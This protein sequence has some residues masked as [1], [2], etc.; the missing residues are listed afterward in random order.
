MSGVLSGLKLDLTRWMLLYV[1]VLVSFLSYF[2]NPHGS[3]LLLS[4]FLAGIVVYTSR[5]SEFSELFSNKKPEILKMVVLM[6]IIF[7]NFTWDNI[8]GGR[9]ASL[10]ANGNPNATAFFF[11]SYIV[12]TSFLITNR[13]IRNTLVTLML[14]FVLIMTTSRMMLLMLLSYYF[15]MYFLNHKKFINWL[16]VLIFIATIVAPFIISLFIQD[17]DITSYTDDASR[18]LVLFDSSSFARIISHEHAFAQFLSSSQSALWGI[19]D[20][21]KGFSGGLYTPHNWFMGMLI[22]YGGLYTIMYSSLL[23]YLVFR[24]EHKFKPALYSLILGAGVASQWEIGLPIM[25]VFLMSLVYKGSKDEQR[26]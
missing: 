17:I 8:D 1:I 19:P 26:E 10:S 22:N 3:I 25:L 13:N 18:L 21:G 24:I 12:A 20:Y 14:I 15:L 7:V 4:S 11:F 23:F 9:Y 5:D 16:G 2:N 6:S